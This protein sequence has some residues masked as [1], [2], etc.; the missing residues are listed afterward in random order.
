MKKELRKL[1][2]LY[3]KL[4]EGKLEYYEWDIISQYF[5]ESDYDLI[6]MYLED[7]LVPIMSKLDYS[8]VKKLGELL[9]KIGNYKLYP[10]DCDLYNYGY[11]ALKLA[12]KLNKHE[13]KK[14][15]ALLYY[16]S[17]NPLAY[18]SLYTRLKYHE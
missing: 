3:K 12:E 15:G 17:D 9:Y 6:A 14:L 1:K 2:S 16:L 18:N 7:Y 13:L 8:K 4:E 11:E 10:E 5:N